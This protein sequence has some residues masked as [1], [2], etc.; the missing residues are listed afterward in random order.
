MKR[1]TKSYD[2]SRPIATGSLTREVGGF[3]L[4]Q[5]NQTFVEGDVIPAGTLARRDE[6]TRKVLIIKTAKVKAID[7]SDAKIVTLESD[8]FIGPIFAVGDKVLK[9]VSGTYAN[10]P[11]IT[12]ISDT[13]NGYIVTLSAAIDGL[14]V[15]DVLQ[16]VYK[17]GS[18]NAAIY[19]AN[20]VVVTDT[21]VRE[22][23]NETIVDVCAD[24][25][26]YAIY[27]RRILPVVSAQKDTTGVYLSENPHIRFTQ[28]Q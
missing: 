17:N 24:T 7:E 28:L 10:A 4:D 5:V 23:G 27:E 3:L 9:T 25:M 18:N 1:R 12:A 13:A 6:T 16:G 21:L 11:S 20:C 8:A 2:G 14:A 22:D 19:K 26:Q 15:G